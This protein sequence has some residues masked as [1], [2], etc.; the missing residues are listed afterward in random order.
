MAI[1]QTFYESVAALQVGLDAWLMHYNT[2]RPQS[3]LHDMG[4][5]LIDTVTLFKKMLRKK[6]SSTSY[7]CS[8][9]M[10]SSARISAM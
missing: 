2:E 6:P 8:P 9:R 3:R 4:R 1:F 7:S 10:A 5:R